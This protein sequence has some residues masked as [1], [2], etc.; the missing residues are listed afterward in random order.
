MN[1]LRKTL[2]RMA[3][4][5]ASPELETSPAASAK[6]GGHGD[7]WG[8][9]VRSAEQDDLLAFL[10]QVVEAVQQPELFQ[11]DG[12]GIAAHSPG[13]RLCATVLLVND[14]LVTAY[15]EGQGGPVWPI[16]VKEIVPWANGIE[17]QIS[18]SCYGASVSFFDTRFYAN[19]RRYAL[20]ETYTF[21]MS[22]FAYTLRRAE[23][24]EVESDEVGAK[25]SFRGAHAY[26]PAD[27][28]NEEADIDDYWFH[29]P[30]EG[31]P[32]HVE[33]AGRQL[34]LF[35]IIMAIPEHFEMALNLFAAPH[36]LAPD[37]AGVVPGDD[38]EGFLWL[39][40]YMDE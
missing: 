39:Q 11:A 26:M 29:S 18:G 19:R 2:R 13:E 3:P 28:G 4:K 5:Q 16:T 32:Q 38:L 21:R 31:E 1:R 14:R 30:L 7:H 15:P 36:A 10:R 25:V 33:L 34:R 12:V 6:P 23:E 27:I 9:I 8:C 40:G 20:G 24:L 17:G 37:M 22:A 35:Q